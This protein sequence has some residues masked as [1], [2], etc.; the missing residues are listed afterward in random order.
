MNKQELLNKAYAG[1]IAQGGPSFEN[2]SCLYTS[3]DGKHCAIGHLL[4]IPAAYNKRTVSA[5][6]WNVLTE[7]GAENSSDIDFLSR[8]QAAH[9]WPALDG[10][11]GKYFLAEFNRNITTMAALE[12]LV[13]PANQA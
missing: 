12:G 13:N 10:L 8:L 6:P 1:I 7:L 9:D 2:G 3:K 4:D 11:E 5:L